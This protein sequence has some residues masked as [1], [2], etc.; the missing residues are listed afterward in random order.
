MVQRIS[1]V[2]LALSLAVG[3]AAAQQRPITGKVVSSATSAPV[4]GA[5]VTVVGTP[6]GA[7]TNDQGEFTL[8]VPSSPVT[9]LIRSVGYRSQQVPV[10]PDA[11]TVTVTLEQDVF[12]LEA[13]VV[14]GQVTGVAQRNLA[15]AVTTLPADEVNRAPTQTLEGALQGKIPGALI[16]ENS[17]APG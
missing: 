8:S 2:S 1:F 5:S 17:G 9:L 12:N 4:A 3:V 6:I 16:Q 13:V 7:V 10:A 14:T 15:N 11:S